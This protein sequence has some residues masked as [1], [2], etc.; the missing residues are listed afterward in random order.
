VPRRRHVDA[1]GDLGL[2]AVADVA[3]LPRRRGAQPRGGLG[4]RALGEGRAAA[5]RAQLE[6]PGPQVA[7]VDVAALV[8]ALAVPQPARQPHPRRLG[9]DER[10]HRADLPVGRQA[11]EL[12]LLDEAEPA[13]RQERLPRHRDLE[14]P[15]VDA[16][17]AVTEETA[18]DRD[19]GVE[20]AR[21]RRELGLDRDVDRHAMQ[22]AG[23]GA[24]Q[25]RAP[26][27][28]AVLVEGRHRIVLAQAELRLQVAAAVQR[29][30]GDGRRRGL[31]AR[32]RRRRRDRDQRPHDRQPAGAH[33]RPSRR[34][35]GAT[36]AAG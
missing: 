26:D 32:R 14:L 23:R 9:H 6:A 33:T 36:V 5:E 4:Q 31:G 27:P 12:G 16:P 1:E 29:E 10:H 20:Q 17:A 30:A 19:R 28:E 21:L 3:L 11:G 22:R 7:L 18:A 35:A 24:D 8:G 2:E 15:G 13:V 34:C 25:A